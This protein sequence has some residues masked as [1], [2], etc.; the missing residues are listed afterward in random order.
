MST[1]CLH[2]AGGEHALTAT[3]CREIVGARKR[4]E[5]RRYWTTVRKSNK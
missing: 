5:F 2:M 4:E 3:P 1:R